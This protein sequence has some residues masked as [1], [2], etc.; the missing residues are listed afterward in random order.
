M[1]APV[2]AVGPGTAVADGVGMTRNALAVVVVVS[3]V[4]LGGLLPAREAGAAR[5]GRKVA[6]TIREKLNRRSM[7]APRANP[8]ASKLVAAAKTRFKRSGVIGADRRAHQR[9]R[10]LADVHK[11]GRTRVRTAGDVLFHPALQG[12]VAFGGMLL[13]G[14][15]PQMALIAGVIVYASSRSIKKTSD[16][17][18]RLENRSIDILEQEGPDAVKRRFS[19]QGARKPDRNLGTLQQN[20][21]LR[22]QHYDD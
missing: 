3:L 19:R 20:R 17:W 5:G 22:N 7:D 6:S 1:D 12:A 9:G 14:V 21:H 13:I 2:R 18:L 4:S 8:G 11:T 10:A 15:Q 16:G